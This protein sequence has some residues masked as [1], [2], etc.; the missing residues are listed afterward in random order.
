MQW[1]FEK[2]DSIEKS[3]NDP[4]KSAKKRKT[5]KILSY[6]KIE[7]VLLKWYTDVRASK[8]P[9]NGVVIKKKAWEILSTW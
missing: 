7:N 2:K 3:H 5:L 9:V 1:F 4:G 6:E 8:I